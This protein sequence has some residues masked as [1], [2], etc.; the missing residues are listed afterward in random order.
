MRNLIICNLNHCNTHE[1]PVC[2]CRRFSGKI[3]FMRL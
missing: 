3:D 2:T 1:T